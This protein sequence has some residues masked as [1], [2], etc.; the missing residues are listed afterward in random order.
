MYV[1]YWLLFPVITTRHNSSCVIALSVTADEC[2]SAVH[3]TWTLM[4]DYKY[5]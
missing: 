4:T 1:Q 5:R 2:Y 3:F